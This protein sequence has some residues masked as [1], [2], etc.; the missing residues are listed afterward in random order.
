[1]G[2]LGQQAVVRSTAE[3][4]AHALPCRAFEPL[5][6][7]ERAVGPWQRFAAG[8]MA[9]ARHREARLDREA[10]VGE[11]RGSRRVRELAKR[12]AQRRP[13]RRGERIV[14]GR[15]DVPAE[16]EQRPADVGER[17]RCRDGRCQPS[18]GDG[19]A[20]ASE[21]A[22]AQAGERPPGR[23]G[24]VGAGGR[25]D[26]RGAQAHGPAR[27][28]SVVGVDGGVAGRLAKGR[29]HEQGDGERERSHAIN[30]RARRDSVGEAAENRAP[31]GVA[32]FRG[33][34]LAVP[35]ARPSG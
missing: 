27:Q 22:G 34:M 19:V 11:A 4:A 1:V 6:A 29:V 24:R 33:S 35:P 8:A 26:R 3:A 25:G 23:V 20:R 17:R 28:R 14:A 32:A 2:A 10:L 16:R 13:R 5:A 15:V 21:V 7:H 31:V 30:G 18:G 12:C 9:Q